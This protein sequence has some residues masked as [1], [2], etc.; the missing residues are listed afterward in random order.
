LGISN[1]YSLPFF[2]QLYAAAKV[3]PSF[4]QNR[5]YAD[6]NYDRILREF[7]LAN[8]VQY[9]S[10]WTLTANP[11]VLQAHSF[12]ALAQKYKFTPEQLFFSTLMQEGMIPLIG[13]CSEKHMEEDLAVIGAKVE[14]TDRKAIMGMLK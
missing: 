2:Q 8:K 10:F 13:T 6:S 7:C 11:H 4:L 14:E 3:K 12:K 1:C 9:Q 5:F